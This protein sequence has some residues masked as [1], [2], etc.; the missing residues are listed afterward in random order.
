MKLTDGERAETTEWKEISKKSKGLREWFRQKY[1][2]P[3]ND[4][5]FM[6]ATETLILEDYL[7]SQA[8]EAK[9]ESES[10]KEFRE[11]SSDKKKFKE[12]QE[13]NAIKPIK[14]LF[15]N[16]DKKKITSKFSVK[17]K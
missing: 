12:W 14:A 11:I 1:N 10:E 7:L 2:L 8:F 17:V 3:L 16:K 9:E 13:K 6:S 5:R 4:E 15:P